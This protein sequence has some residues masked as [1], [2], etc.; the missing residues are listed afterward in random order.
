M[1]LKPQSLFSYASDPY[2]KLYITSP[3]QQIKTT[4]TTE[5][6]AQLSDI[7]QNLQETIAI[8]SLIPWRLFTF[9]LFPLMNI[10][11]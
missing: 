7:L 4:V 5:G 6:R 11:L 10:H 9:L 1:C 8:L 2:R 3:P